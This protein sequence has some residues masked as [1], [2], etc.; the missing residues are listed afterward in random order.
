VQVNLNK[1]SVTGRGVQHAP[2]Y[3]AC[4]LYS[5]VER[6]PLG[7]LDALENPT[8]DRKCPEYGSRSEKKEGER[9]GDVGVQ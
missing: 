7:V 3:D 6:D 9:N 2:G 1:K 5:R 8:I 4:P